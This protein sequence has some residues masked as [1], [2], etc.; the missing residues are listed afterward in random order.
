MNKSFINSAVR[1]YQAIK[2]ERDCY[3]IMGECPKDDIDIALGDFEKELNR[4]NY[5]NTFKKNDGRDG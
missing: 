4:L 5:D 2:Q 3:M 1:L